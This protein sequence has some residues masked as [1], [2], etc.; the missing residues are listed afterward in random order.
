MSYQCEIAPTTPT[1][2]LIAYATREPVVIVHRAEDL[3]EDDNQ[4]GEE[5]AGNDDSQEM[6]RVR[7]ETRVRIMR[8]LIRMRMQ[9]IR[10]LLVQRC[11]LVVVLEGR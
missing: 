1:T 8:A 3:E 7:V 11:R 2:E 6:R 4:A 10:S 5:G 9:R